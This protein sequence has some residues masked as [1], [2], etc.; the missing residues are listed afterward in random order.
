MVAG[1]GRAN[2][3]PLVGSSRAASWRLRGRRHWLRREATRDEAGEWGL[4]DPKDPRH[5]GR[6]WPPSAV[7]LGGQRCDSH[8]N[9]PA[10]RGGGVA[11][12]WHCGSLTACGG[13]RRPCQRGPTIQLDSS[14]AKACHVLV[15][16][17]LDASD[18]E[19]VTA[20]FVVTSR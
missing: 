10:C 20:G 17:W 19:A 12:L 13:S 4:R 18:A 9:R 2:A 11:E 7:L 15:C 14:D 8:S 3:L 16:G 1:R 6:G 5:R